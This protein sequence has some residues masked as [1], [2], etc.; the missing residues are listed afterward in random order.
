MTDD[1]DVSQWTGCSKDVV[2]AKAHN[3]IWITTTMWTPKLDVPIFCDKDGIE[4][5][6]SFRKRYWELARDEMSSDLVNS[7]GGKDYRASLAPDDGACAAD[8]VCI[9]AQT[10]SAL[11]G[12]H[13]TGRKAFNGKA[14]SLHEV[15]AKDDEVYEQTNQL[16]QATEFNGVAGSPFRFD[17]PGL[18]TDGS[19]CDA[20]C[21]NSATC[22]GDGSAAMVVKQFNIDAVEGSPDELIDIFSYD[23][24]AFRKATTDA[25]RNAAYNWIRPLRFSNGNFW[26][27]AVAHPK[28][29]NGGKACVPGYH[30]AT[31]P[32]GP[33]C[34][35]DDVTP[36]CAKGSEAVGNKCVPCAAHTFFSIAR[37]GCAKCLP[38]KMQLLEGQTQCDDCALGEF[39]SGSP[40]VC[41]KCSPGGLA[42]SK[43]SKNCTLCAPGKYSNA[44]AYICTDCSNGKSTNGKIG[45]PKCTECAEGDFSPDRGQESCK[46]CAP[47][48]FAG[49]QGLS[50]CRLDR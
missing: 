3:S 37:G 22:T 38:G 46:Q 8:A 44:G 17:C 23:K 28:G 30:I 7:L 35:P 12:I 16:L 50:K 39:S 42:D 25:E 4:T 11:M 2:R 45:S 9:H 40:M 1:P 36:G 43:G 19:A 27:G 10:L 34:V 21:R 5:G 48:T 41:T 14:Y 6:M 33:N 13:P 24:G 20:A 31:G 29:G 26:G 15:L 47:G 32:A 18:P 49:T